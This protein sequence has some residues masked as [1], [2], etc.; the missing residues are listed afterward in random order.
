MKFMLRW[1]ANS[2][3]F[4]LALF[5]VYSLTAPR[6]WLQAVWLGGILAVFLGLLNS[7]VRP[8][9]R[10]SSRTFSA[11]TVAVLTVLVNALILQIFIWIGAPLSATNITGVLVAAAFLSLLAGVLNWLV[12]FK[13]KTTQGPRD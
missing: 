4:Y 9:H 5:L 10:L 8:L 12:G 13:K 11:V 7:L 2:I 3:A 1:I 6:F